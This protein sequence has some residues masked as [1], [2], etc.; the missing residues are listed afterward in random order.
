VTADAADRRRAREREQNRLAKS[1][2]RS[3]QRKGIRLY[4]IRA[5]E[6]VHEAIKARSLDAGFPV[7]AAEREACNP[8]KVAADLTNVVE[9]WALKYLRERHR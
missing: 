2:Q 1:R 4:T 5:G 8:T 6:V 3:R 7:E 9:Q